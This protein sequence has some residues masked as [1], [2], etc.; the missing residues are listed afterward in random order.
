QFKEKKAVKLIEFGSND[1]VLLKEFVKD[2]KFMCLGVDPAINISKIAKKEGV[3]VYLGNFDVKAA[4]EIENKYGKFDYITGSNVFAHIDD[5]HSVVSAAKMLLKNNGSFVTEVHYLPNLIEL[6]QYDF[7]YH[8]HLN[9]YTLKSLIKLF[10]IHKLKL[11]N[12]EMI[13]THGGS[14][15]VTVS[16]N[17]NK[18]ASLKVKNIL[19]SEKII[20]K[21]YFDRFNKNILIQR[22]KI[23]Q[24]LSNLIASKKRIVGYGASGRG[25]ILLN[26]CNIDSKK[27]SY[28][29][30]E[31]PL[32]AGK[33]MP[34]VKLPI[35][36]IDYFKKDKVKVDYVLIIAWNYTDP[37]IKK[38]R[39]IDKDIKF[40]VPFPY[41]YI[42]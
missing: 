32:R 13:Q 15:R 10:E 14:I 30:D 8:E 29:V 6:N 23:N 27:L 1:G 39:K 25:T 2:K 22:E 5:I 9:Y 33:L 16:P 41:P 19:Q 28:I 37:I 24:M 31:S 21:K 20:N 36:S 7:I 38:V 11:I 34:G 18:K 35:F 17:L 42:I 40:I 3:N 12:A 4:L 26:Y